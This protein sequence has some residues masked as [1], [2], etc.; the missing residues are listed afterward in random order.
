MNPYSQ[1]A[2]KIIK[3]QE[4]LIGPVAL[5]QA[6]KVSG[7]SVSS[8][9]DVKIVGDAKDVLVH[10]VDQYA[11]LFGKA[12]IEVCREVARDTKILTAEQLPDILR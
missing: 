8:V 1:I 4:E 9:D 7:L 12:S 3:E 11:K 10:L 2:S 6:K 5:E